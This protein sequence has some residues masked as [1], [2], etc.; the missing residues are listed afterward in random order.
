MRAVCATLCVYVSFLAFLLPISSSFFLYFF[1]FWLWNRCVV[2][3]SSLALCTCVHKNCVF[4]TLY[5][6]KWHGKSNGM[7]FE[8]RKKKA[9]YIYI[10]RLGV[11]VREWRDGVEYISSSGSSMHVLCCAVVVCCLLLPPHRTAI[12]TIYNTYVEKVARL[13]CL[14]YALVFFFFLLLFIA[15]V[16]DGYICCVYNQQRCTRNKNRE[17]GAKGRKEENMYSR[18]VSVF[19]AAKEAK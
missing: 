11:G 1:F 10:Y 8:R 9:T 3:V 6:S 19:G 2:C 17:N 12:Q 4:C 14:L 16:H 18:S 15:L 13:A 5:M 7:G